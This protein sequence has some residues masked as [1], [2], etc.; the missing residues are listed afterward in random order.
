MHPG[1]S[2]QPTCPLTQ[3][4]HKKGSIPSPK[5]RQKLKMTEIPMVSRDE[6]MWTDPG[7][8]NRL[9][10][11]KKESAA[12]RSITPLLRG[13]VLTNSL[14]NYQTLPGGGLDAVSLDF[15]RSTSLPPS[16]NLCQGL[17][18]WQQFTEAGDRGRAYQ[19]E[20]NGI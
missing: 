14:V 2:G 5:A 1:S 12:W 6:V 7:P 10:T 13:G 16:A 17:R 4:T 20:G 18:A 11:Q 9:R 15:I 8:G 3:G 19:I